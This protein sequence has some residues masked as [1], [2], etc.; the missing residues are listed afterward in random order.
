MKALTFAATFIL[1]FLAACSGKKEAASATAGANEEAIIRK[2][3]IGG[4][5]VRSIP[6]ATVFKMSGDYADNV[7]V[8]LN[9]DGTLAYYPA[10]SDIT[11]NSSPVALADG[12]YLNRQGLG[13][14]S[15]FLTYTFEQYRNLPK[16]PSHEELLEAVIPGSSVTEF[17]TLPVSATEAFSNPE[18]CLIY[19]PK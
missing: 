19:L 15:V 13:S 1:L 14:G 9:P 11:V 16:A 17:M 12:W 5:E 8:T 6:N 18:E 10:P 7:A 2:N 4:V 3:V